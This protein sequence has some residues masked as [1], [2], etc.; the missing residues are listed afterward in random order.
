MKELLKI[1]SFRAVDFGSYL[2]AYKY[3][4]KKLNVSQRK[5]KFSEFDLYYFR[6]GEDKN[7]LEWYQNNL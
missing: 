4:F 2:D 5:E 7:R 6:N 3:E 1:P